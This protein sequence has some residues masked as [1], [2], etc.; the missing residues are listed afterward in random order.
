MNLPKVARKLHRQFAQ[1]GYSDPG[2]TMRMRLLVLLA[3]ILPILQTPAQTQIGV[4][5]HG[6]LFEL[7]VIYTNQPDTSSS[8]NLGNYT[9][10]PGSLVASRVAATNYGVT[11]T[12]DGLTSNFPGNLTID[13]V[14][15]SNGDPLPPESLAF[16]TGHLFW[17]TIGGQELGLA[18]NATAIGANSFDVFSG[19]IQQREDYEEATF[20]G[21]A[22][23]GNFERFVRVVFVEPAG[24]GAKAGLM[25]RES[26]DEGKPRPVDSEDID[27]GFSRYLELA[28]NS[29]VTALAESTGQGHLILKRT[30][31]AS[32]VTDI[33]D[34]GVAPQFPDVWLRIVRTG[35]TF[36]LYRGTNATDW[37]HIRDETFPTNFPDTAFVGVA[38]TPQNDDL[39]ATGD[40]RKS[41]IAKFRTY[42]GNEKQPGTLAIKLVGD[43]AELSWTGDGILET[44]P[45]ISGT[46]T[47]ASS[48]QNPQNIALTGTAAFFRLR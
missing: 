11:L 28:V 26:L 7:S 4:L 48:Q 46:W 25:V 42:T 8:L 3:A 36:S 37:I 9:I 45:T 5:K 47:T 12:A 30:E 32:F 21:E 24:M 34:D 15:D 23:T 6:D 14:L 44:A 2:V 31:T 22:V 18:P 33:F 41:F 13:G 20:V 29:P 19:G 43:H 17:T 35:Q 27:Q 1:T 40:V 39:P 10:V 38:F 16:N